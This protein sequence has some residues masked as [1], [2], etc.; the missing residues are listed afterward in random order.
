MKNIEKTVQ[1]IFS[2][3]FPSSM[4]DSLEALNMDTESAWDSMKQLSIITA[5][6]NEFDIFI[7]VGD[8][9]KLTTYKAIINFLS[10]H[11]E[12]G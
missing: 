5:I 12:V 11:P 10:A 3:L 7:D 8:A 9:V 1:Y 2:E 6:E 4:E